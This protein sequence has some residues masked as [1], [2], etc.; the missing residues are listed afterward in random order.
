MG[1]IYMDP[2][3]PFPSCYGQHLVFARCRFP[4]QAVSV[5]N[6]RKVALWQ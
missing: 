3:R 4:V 6:S 1:I 2:E 5:K